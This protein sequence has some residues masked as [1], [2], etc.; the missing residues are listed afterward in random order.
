MPSELLRQ[1]KMLTE[2]KIL[3]KEMI[4]RRKNL[5]VE[6]RKNFS[7]Q[8]IKKFLATPIYK[9]SSVIMAYMPMA[10][11]VQLQEFFADA[12]KKKKILAIPFIV[13][14]GIIKP[15][16]L[17]NLEVLEVG[18]FGILTVKKNFREFIDEKKI[19]CII[20]PGAAF[21]IH[22]NR[23]GLGGGYYDRFLKSVENAKKIA[24]AF[25]FQVTENLPTESHDMS[26]DLII[27]EKNFFIKEK[28]V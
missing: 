19:D 14:R 5:S 15:V 26:V 18:E 3:R 27:T 10:D 21:D 9:K 11:E 12:F 4:S 6:E 2:K 28:G 13:E 22:G 24:L 1:K 25:D 20:V 17:P 7:R 16:I 23:L 8:I